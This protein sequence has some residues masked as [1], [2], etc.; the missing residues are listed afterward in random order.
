VLGNPPFL[1][2][3]YQSKEQKDDLAAVMQG[4]HG[5]GVLDF[6]CGWY[7]LAARYCLDQKTQT[8]N[9]PLFDVPLSR[10]IMRPSIAVP[11]P[12]VS[13]TASD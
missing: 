9:L 5:A 2:Y 7:I 1:G 11:R 8:V 3:S 10:F 4:I 13:Q 6:V 12:S